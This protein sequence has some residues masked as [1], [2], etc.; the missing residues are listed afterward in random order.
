MELAQESMGWVGSVCSDQTSI[1]VPLHA[2]QENI[3][4]LQQ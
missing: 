4:L 2:K 1:V 3:C